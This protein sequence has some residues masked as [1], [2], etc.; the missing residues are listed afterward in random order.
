MSYKNKEKQRE[1]CKEWVKTRRMSF[2][3][4]KKCF[5]CGSTENLVLHHRNPEEKEGHCIWSWAES[6]RLREIEK[7]DILC[8]KCHIE[9]HAKLLEKNVHGTDTMY[10]KG[11]RCTECKKF[12]SD[13]NKRFRKN[14]STAPIAQT[15]RATV[16]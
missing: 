5:R 9:H 2:F 12:K 11:C 6:R 4:G 10:N 16:L 14:C 1:Y 13:K 7:C 15:D 8:K 3:S